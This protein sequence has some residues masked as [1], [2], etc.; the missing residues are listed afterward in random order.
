[1]QNAIMYREREPRHRGVVSDQVALADPGM[2]AP[3]SNSRPSRSRQM[4]NTLRQ[5]FVYSEKRVRDIIFR[6]I[7]ATL[8]ERQSPVILSRLTREAASRG[9]VRS[10]QAGFDFSNWDTA[11]K[12]TVNAMLGAG[13][14]LARDSRPIALTIS[15][16]ATEV[17]KLI[18]GFEDITEA[19]LL[20]L[21]IRKLGDVST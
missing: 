4:V 10:Q 6:E 18:P 16:Q 17:A 3:Q 21:L 9:R 8:Q 19:Y 14:L 11:S 15:A 5:E 1:M 13:A 12:A 2:N 20:E 7:E